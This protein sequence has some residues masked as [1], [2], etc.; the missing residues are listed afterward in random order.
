[1][2]FHDSSGCQYAVRSFLHKSMD[3]AWMGR[4]MEQLSEFATGTKLKVPSKKH[5]RACSGKFYSFLYPWAQ[6]RLVTTSSHIGWSFT[7]GTTMQSLSY[8]HQL[9]YRMFCKF[10]LFFYHQK[11]PNM[12]EASRQSSPG[13]W[14]AP[15]AA[16]PAPSFI[17]FLISLSLLTFFFWHACKMKVSN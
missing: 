7:T 8:S 4:L 13:H 12:E 16:H 1:M 2:F 17:T 3:E 5:G 15:R 6:L 11:C 9:K 10:C 14:W